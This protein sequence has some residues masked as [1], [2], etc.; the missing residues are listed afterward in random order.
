VKQHLIYAG[1][2]AADFI[3]RHPKRIAAAI[4]AVLL[5]GGSGAFA[6][7]SLAPGAPPVEPMRLVF[8]AVEPA[9]ALNAQTDLLE[10]HSFTLYRSEQ[11]R[12]TD[13]PEALL[14]RL[15]LADPAAAAFLRKNATAR[16]AL[17]SRAGRAVTVEAND[18]LEL[19]SLRTRWIDGDADQ[20]FKRLVVERTGNDFSVRI[21]TAPLEFSQR[22]AGG[23]IRNTLYSA[24]DEAGLPDSVTKQLI[25]IF[26]SSIDFHRGL[27]K[28]DQFSV[29]YETL[30]AD[31]EP[32]RA[33]KIL[34]AEII[35]RGKARQAVWFKDEGAVKGAYYSFDGQSL[36]RPYLMSP[37]T[38]TR[39]ITSGFGMRSHPVYGYSREHTGIDYAA[40]V[41]TPVRTIGDGVIEFAG[42][43]KGYGNIIIVRHRNRKDS[44]AYAHLSRISVKVGEHVAQG[45]TIG[46]TGATGVVTGPHLHFE[47][48]VNNTPRNP[49]VVLADQHED[50]AIT[51]ASK[52][53]FAKLAADMKTQLAAAAGSGRNDLE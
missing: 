25:A 23:V 48:R 51:S 46:A 18:R 19:Q 2:A 43:K 42:V 1:L 15:G 7:A 41:G 47:F 4:G 39:S 38:I 36:R 32:L 28:G 21:E 20:G 40:P 10:A 30:D 53:A 33:G 5:A 44:T 31:G 34:S 27:H 3:H 11:T 29:V 13:T 45:D 9:A 35:N 12:A 26:E 50:I 37:M 22:V 49:S 52:A 6:V 14:Q 16:Q 17:F 8:E 24:T